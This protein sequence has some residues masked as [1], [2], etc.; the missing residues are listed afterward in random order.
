MCK[1]SEKMISIFKNTHSKLVFIN[2]QKGC[3]TRNITQWA[4]MCHNFANETFLRV[5][6]TVWG[7]SSR[8]QKFSRSYCSLDICNSSFVLNL[9]KKVLGEKN[10]CLFLAKIKATINFFLLSFTLFEI[11]IF[12]PKIQLWFLEK[13]VEFFGVK[14]SWKCCGFGLFTC[15]QLWF[16]EKN[17][18]KNLGEKLVKM[19]WFW[20]F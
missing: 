16:H 1:D 6:N 18:Q 5:I 9:T 20:T 15:W 8:Q 19:F 2:F 12:C 17:C 13:I 3:L 4:E 14:N 11:F 10:P 7:D